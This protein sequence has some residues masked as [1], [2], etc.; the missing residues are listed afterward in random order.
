MLVRPSRDIAN[1]SVLHDAFRFF[2]LVRF[3]GL[4]GA[5]SDFVRIGIV[6]AGRGTDDDR[7]GISRDLKDILMDLLQLF[8]N[9][10][11]RSG[12]GNVLKIPH[13]EDSGSGKCPATR[14]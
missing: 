6:M 7:G 1:S 9:K 11:C 14:N 13:V 12:E 10:I 2:G 5:K 3:I 4:V 8:S